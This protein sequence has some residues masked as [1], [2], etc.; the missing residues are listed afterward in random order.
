M[1]DHPPKT[2][3]QVP[4][5]VNGS[6]NYAPKKQRW[7]NMQVNGHGIDHGNKGP[8]WKR[9]LM[10]L[11]GPCKKINSIYKCGY[12]PFRYRAWPG[13]RKSSWSRWIVKKSSS[14]SSSGG[15][16]SLNCSSSGGVPSL[17]CSSNGGVSEGTS[18][19][20]EGTSGGLELDKSS[21]TFSSAPLVYQVTIESWR[22]HS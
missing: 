3:Y 15:V 21:L 6:R 22:K 13:Q 9:L 12:C 20:G 2:P 16:P 10:V 8:W 19:V 14:S 1:A 11:W 17:K 7:T 18:C 4:S 5:E